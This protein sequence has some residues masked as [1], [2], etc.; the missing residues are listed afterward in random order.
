VPIVA[1]DPHTGPDA[2][3]TIAVH[4]FDGARAAT[5][6]LIALGHRRIAHLRG[7]TDLESAHQRERGYRAA[8]E[9]AGIP[10]DPALVAEG[11][12]RA[13][14]ATMGANALLDLA[15][16][17]T[18]VFAANDLS[19]LEVVRCAA[20]RGLRVPADLSVVGFDDI[21]EAASHTPQLTTVRQPL[22]AMG[23]AAVEMLL[24]ML[25]DGEPEPIRMPAELIPRG[26]TAPPVR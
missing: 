11:G 17:P 7:R 25:D 10:F 21:P 8:L 22:E 1:V 26:S 15:D 5:E 12:Y 23:A 4:S 14:S 6:H 16:R 19:A 3:A 2:P 18:A 9:A 20:E 13:A 24:R